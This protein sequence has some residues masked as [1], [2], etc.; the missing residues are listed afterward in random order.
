[1]RHLYVSTL[2]VG[3]LK[4]DTFLARDFLYFEAPKQSQGGM[5]GVHDTFLIEFKPLYYP[6]T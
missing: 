5:V 2:T 6:L 1:M 4:V 3:S